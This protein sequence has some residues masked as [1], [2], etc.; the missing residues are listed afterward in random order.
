MI[1]RARSTHGGVSW[2]D[3][4]TV[5]RSPRPPCRRSRCVAGYG[6]RGSTAWLCVEAS[7]SGVLYG[8]LAV[9]AVKCLYVVDTHEPRGDGPGALALDGSLLVLLRWVV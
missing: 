7:R 8:A 1:K 4:A 3:D 6:Q 2:A 5:T 9:G